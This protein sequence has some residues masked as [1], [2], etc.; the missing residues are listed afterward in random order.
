MKTKKI[1]VMMIIGGFLAYSLTAM[2]SHY[3][4]THLLLLLLVLEFLLRFVQSLHQYLSQSLAF[5]LSDFV[6]LHFCL[7]LQT[8]SMHTTATNVN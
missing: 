4:H 3:V 6:L 8:H 7:P 1:T 2:L 5:C